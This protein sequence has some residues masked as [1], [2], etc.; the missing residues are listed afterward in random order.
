MQ[1]RSWAP[2]ARCQSQTEQSTR[3]VNRRHA[4][5]KL[6]LRCQSQTENSTRDVN[7][8]VIDDGQREPRAMPGA[9]MSSTDTARCKSTK[10]SCF[11][12]DDARRETKAEQTKSAGLMVAAEWHMAA[13]ERS[14][15]RTVR[16][17]R[18]TRSCASQRRTRPRQHR[19]APQGPS[20]HRAP[21]HSTSHH[22]IASRSRPNTGSFNGTASSAK[23]HGVESPSDAILMSSL[24]INHARHHITSSH[25][26]T[27]SHPCIIFSPHITRS[28][29]PYATSLLVSC[30]T[31]SRGPVARR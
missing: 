3:V 4:D 22:R 15:W 31:G 21:H 12:A 29:S 18:K 10:R 14:V 27:S 9:D 6:H 5:R 11:A 1:R 24:D 19:S 13:S 7:R 25:R 16:F 30:G 26:I 23:Q 2:R 28:F 17:G 20:G 8:K